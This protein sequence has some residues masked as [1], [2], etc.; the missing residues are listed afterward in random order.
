[1][2]VE[3]CSG[4]VSS[5]SLRKTDNAS[6]RVSKEHVNPAGL[7]LGDTFYF[8]TKHYIDMIKNNDSKQMVT[9]HGIILKIFVDFFFFECIATT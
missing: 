9:L 5:T 2:S 6:R 1:M 4:R 7:R 3:K 8:S